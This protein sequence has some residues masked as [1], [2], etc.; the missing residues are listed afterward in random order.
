MSAGGFER[1]PSGQDGLLKCLLGNGCRLDL[2]DE[3]DF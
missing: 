3:V 2:I 1:L